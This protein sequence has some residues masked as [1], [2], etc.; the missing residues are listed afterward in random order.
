M[1]T[2]L[3]PNQA[4]PE[5]PLSQSQRAAL[6]RTEPI[7]SLALSRMDPPPPHLP[8]TEDTR[9]RV[10]TLSDNVF[11]PCDSHVCVYVCVCGRDSP[12][13]G[14]GW[15]ALLR[16]IPTYKSFVGLGVSREVRARFRVY[17]L[18]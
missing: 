8:P 13:E 9:E 16:T 10:W 17:R 5:H 12:G 2:A 4:A 18:E 3:Q 1:L 14:Q 6:A 15:L 11:C 7:L